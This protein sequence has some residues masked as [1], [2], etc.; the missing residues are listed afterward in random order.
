MY[1][2]VPHALTAEPSSRPT[3]GPSEAVNCDT[4]APGPSLHTAKTYVSALRSAGVDINTVRGVFGEAIDT[5]LDAT[6]SL[7]DMVCDERHRR[8]FD[9]AAIA[10]YTAAAETSET[11]NRVTFTVADVCGA[12]IPRLQHKSG[13][14]ATS[15]ADA[16]AAAAQN[17]ATKTAPIHILFFS[18]SSVDSLSE[19]RPSCDAHNPSAAASTEDAK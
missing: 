3:R 18:F 14:T 7:A 1:H 10:T 2:N 11:A 13:P 6:Q 16:A 15:A 19:D 12:G 9:G 5:E 4:T 8:S 17:T